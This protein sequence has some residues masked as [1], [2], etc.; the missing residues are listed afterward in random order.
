MVPLWYRLMRP[1]CPDRSEAWTQWT[2]WT[3]L[4]ASTPR[5]ARLGGRKVASSNLAAPTTGKPA[6]KQTQPTFARAAVLLC[7]RRVLALLLLRLEAAAHPGSPKKTSVF[8]YPWVVAR[9]ISGPIVRPATHRSELS[10]AFPRLRESAPL[11]G[12][13]YGRSRT[14]SV[15]S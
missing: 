11:S 1:M 6:R 15:L 10:A 12:C 9:N 5:V 7:P 14:G 3:I 8:D 4:E 2:I 13:D